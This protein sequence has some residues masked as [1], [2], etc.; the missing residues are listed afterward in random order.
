MASHRSAHKRLLLD[1]V[2][3]HRAQK[4][5]RIVDTVLEKIY[6]CYKMWQWAE[7]QVNL[8]VPGGSFG[9]LAGTERQSL[10]SAFKR[11][12]QV[13][14]GSLHTARTNAARLSWILHCL[15]FKCL[16]EER[17]MRDPLTLATW[18]LE[19]FLASL[20]ALPRKHGWLIGCIEVFLLTILILFVA[21]YFVR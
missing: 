13:E 18:L 14:S 12:N 21:W 19:K 8:W 3:Y 16:F 5:A 15:V 7:A 6:I 2:V 20:L 1:S 10:V 11:L 4:V 17:E 9:G